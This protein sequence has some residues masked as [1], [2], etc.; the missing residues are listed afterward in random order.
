MLYFIVAVPHVRRNILKN[1]W[2]GG[3]VERG[4]GHHKK[5]KTEKIKWKSVKGRVLLSQPPCYAAVAVA[6]AVAVA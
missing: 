1:I 2:A 5:K 3:K 4:G 6:V